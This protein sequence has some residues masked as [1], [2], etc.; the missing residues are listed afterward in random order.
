MKRVFIFSFLLFGVMVLAVSPA[1]AGTGKIS[2]RIT[3]SNGDGVIANILVVENSM[4][5]P[6]DVDGN[7][8]ILNVPPG[9]YTVKITAVGYG[10]Q[11]FNGVSVSSDVTTTLNATLA[12]QALEMAPREIEYEKPAVILGETYGSNRMTAKELAARP[13][14]DVKSILATQRGFKVDPN[15]GLHVRGGRESEMLVKVDGTDFRDPLVTGSRQLVNMSALNVEEIEVLTGGDARYGGFQA[16]LINVTTPE[17]S[18]TDYAGV[19]ELRSDRM[20][21]RAD[22]Y[23]PFYGQSND[24]WHASFDQDQYDYSLS[25]PVPFAD[26]LLGKQKLSFFTSGTARMGDT[27]TP[28][29]VYRPASDILGIGLNLPERQNNDYSTFWKFTYRMDPTRKFNFSFQRDYS[30]W[31]IYPDGEAAYDGNNGWQYKY[32]VANRPYAETTRQSLSL[33]YSH[34][35]SKNTLYEVTVGNFATTTYV[36]PRGKNP[37]QFTLSKDAEDDNATTTG[38]TDQ[39]KDGFP[40]GY[41]DANRNGKYD[42]QGEGYDDINGNGRWDR[43]EDFVDLNGNGI[44]DPAEPWVDVTDPVTGRNNVG[45]WD[46]WDPYVDLNHNGRW[47]PAEPQL[48]EQDWNHNGHWDGEPFQDANHNG[49]YDGFGEGY[50]DKNLNGTMDKRDLYDASKEAFGE[51]YV[52][53]DYW[54]DTGEPFIDLPDANGYYNGVWDPGEYWYDLPSSYVSPL[55]RN[56]VPSTNGVYDKPNGAFDEYEL[57]TYSAK[58]DYGYDPRYPVLYTYGDVSNGMRDETG[59]YTGQDWLR[60]PPLRDGTPGY[61]AWIEGKSTWTN[62]TL[63]DG[64]SDYSQRA[65]WIFDIPNNQWDNGKPKYPGQTGHIPVEGYTDYNNNGTQDNLPDQFLNPGQ[66]DANSFWEKRESTEWSAK[67]DLTSQVNKFH[68]LKT[69]FELKYRILTMNSISGPD[70]VYSN[71]DI[72]LPPDSPFPDR[73]SVRDF[74]QHKPWEGA[75]YFQDKMEFEGMIVRAGLRSDFVIQPNDLIQETQTQIDQNQPGALLAKRGQFT[76][77]PRLGISHPITE[78]SKLYFNYGHYY[79]TPQFQYFYQSATANLS[80][81]TLVGNPNLEY[82]KTV[83]YEVGVNTE[84]ADDWVADVSGYYR[85]VF[86]QIGTVAF[87]DGPLVLNRYFNL[88][89]ARA[90]GFEFQLE[91]KF[92]SMWALTASYD[93]SYA[94][95]K[96]SAAADGLIQ[97]NANAP[98]NQDEHPLNWDQTH[99]ISTYLTLMVSEKD[100]PKPFNIAIP[101]NWLATLEVTYGSGYPY[102][103]GQYTTSTPANL[104][105]TNSARMPATLTTDLKFDKY[106]QITKKMKIATGFEI[107]NLLN[108]ANVR[109]I[110]PATGNTYQPVNQLDPTWVPGGADYGMNP[111]NYSAPRQIL[112]HFKLQ[113]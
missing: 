38:G 20:F 28:Y 1:L 58:L 111:R 66:W 82:E 30:K 90:R 73:G 104:I 94:Y 110:Y 15:G 4:G 91:K 109:S 61:L 106:W 29:N 12:E 7:F 93:F 81:N 25:G 70:Q 76:I 57:F 37:D 88:G 46:P 5:A 85:D 75:V 98:E 103:P 44:Y 33:S 18:M 26:K 10:A 6:A 79:Q 68:E 41:V 59:R 113:V 27:Y 96:E 40:D 36:L 53:G 13:I 8:V 107:Y 55:Q 47:D 35:V 64:G 34:N 50:D 54:N 84:F 99:T 11:T 23:K 9:S 65:N 101:N 22:P 105:E 77:A 102:T 71:T 51:P 92:S 45:V 112:L 100:H 86:N 67:L 62:T 95:G 19:L 43:G 39:N 31:D 72:P 87:R 74:Y 63:N 83:S 97:R 21:K 89:Y 60:L 52:D 49:K 78:R 24:L 42:G 69:G 16:A 17:G 48:P 56:A 14:T 108:R 32:D 3:D 2:G 80:P